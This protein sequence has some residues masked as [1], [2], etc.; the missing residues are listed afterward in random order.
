MLRRPP[1]HHHDPPVPRDGRPRL[2]DQI[3]EGVRRGQ[4]DDDGNTLDIALDTGGQKFFGGIS[5]GPVR[6]SANLMRYN[7]PVLHDPADISFPPSER[8]VPIH[9]K[10]FV[11]EGCQLLQFAPKMSRAYV[12]R[13]R[14]ITDQFQDDFGCTKDRFKRKLAKQIKVARVGPREPDQE[15]EPEGGKKSRFK[16]GVKQCNF[17]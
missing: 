7:I 1:D 15:G 12:H 11:F 9:G 3:P 13:F 8:H 10:A 6:L 16:C 17:S 14:A 4:G 2:P 5:G